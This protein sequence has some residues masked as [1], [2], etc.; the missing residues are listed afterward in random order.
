MRMLQMEDFI[1]LYKALFISTQFQTH[2][3][4]HYKPIFFFVV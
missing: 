2:F 1:S 4:F 3:K